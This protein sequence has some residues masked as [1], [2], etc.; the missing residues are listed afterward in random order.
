MRCSRVRFFILL[1]NLVL[2]LCIIEHGTEAKAAA[3]V[4]S[5][6][7]N[8]KGG[9]GEGDLIPIPDHYL[10]GDEEEVT[11]DDDEEEDVI[12]EDEAG[13]RE[14]KKGGNDFS[15]GESTSSQGVVCVS[16]VAAVD[17]RSL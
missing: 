5:G 2:C 1:A 13:G 8:K 16:C 14:L 4:S 6:R 17:A 3:S 15:R 12:E 11:Y 10:D 7:N 9:G